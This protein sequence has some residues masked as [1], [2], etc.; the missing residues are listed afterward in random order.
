MDRTKVLIIEDNDDIREST[1]EI[2]ELANYEVLQAVNGKEG[3]AMAV[4]ELPDILVLVATSP[5]PGEDVLSVP[6]PQADNP[7]T[8]AAMSVLDWN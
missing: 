6:P 2:L 5:V 8:I 1:T 7:S 4:Q 3:V